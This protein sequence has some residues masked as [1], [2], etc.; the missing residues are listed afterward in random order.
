MQC[1]HEACT[2]TVPVDGEYCSPSC[3]TGDTGGGCFCGHADCAA[4]EMPLTI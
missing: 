3:R 2:C 4:A 1:N